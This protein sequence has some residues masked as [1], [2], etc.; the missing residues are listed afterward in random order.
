MHQCS[1][2]SADKWP[3]AVEDDDIR[4]NWVGGIWG[5]SV[6]IIFATFLSVQSYS[7]IK[8]VVFL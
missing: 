5:L 6:L 4:G 2:L 7:K 3:P 1:L 8:S